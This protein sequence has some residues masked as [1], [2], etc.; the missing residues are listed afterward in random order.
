MNTRT[1]L[2]SGIIAFLGEFLSPVQAQQIVGKLLDEKQEP[3]S[4]ANVVLLSLPDSTFIQGTVTD[5]QGAFSMQ[6][7][8]NASKLLRVTYIGYDKLEKEC[9]SG[10]VGT[11]SLISSAAMIEET[12]ITAS[13]AVHRLKNGNL[14]TDVANSLLSKEHSS[15]NLLKKIPGMTIVQGNLEVFGA[16]API[17]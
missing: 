1:F 3:V 12:V 5:E 11:L 10:D 7:N 15:M 4:F 17:V 14:V 8:D 2:I 13:R 16:G 6:I 9:T